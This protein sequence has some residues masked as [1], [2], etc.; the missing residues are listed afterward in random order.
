MNDYQVGQILFLIAKNNVLPIQVIEE[1][2]RTTLNGKEKTYIIK[3]PDKKQTQV[4]IAEIKGDIFN[5]K[6]TAY[7]FMINNATNAIGVMIEDAVTAAKSVFN[8]DLE[9]ETQD[10]GTDDDI[11]FSV[12]KMQ[13]E[14]SNSKIKIDL[15]DGQVGNINPE[16]LEKLRS[17]K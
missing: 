5:S 11:T 1:V 15:G 9:E 16:D 4:D 6:E 10:L 12:L 13:P 17:V 8:I 3:F 7:Q 2:I 14:E